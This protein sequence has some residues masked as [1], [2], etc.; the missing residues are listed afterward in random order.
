MLESRLGRVVE[1][2]ECQAIEHHPFGSKDFDCRRGLS[3]ENDI[4]INKMTYK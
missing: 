1:N 3:K 4:K 2:L